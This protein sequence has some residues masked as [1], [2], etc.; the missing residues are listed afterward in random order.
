MGFGRSYTKP[1]ARWPTLDATVSLSLK[2][3]IS[4]VGKQQPPRAE[5]VED[6][7]DIIFG[8]RKT[9]LATANLAEA[10]D[11]IIADVACRMDND[12]AIERQIIFRV[13]TL[14]ST[15]LSVLSDIRLA[16]EKASL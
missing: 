14:Q 13:Q 7:R 16:S 1:F 2:R 4:F 5:P 8:H 15:G 10:L 3:S 6:L 9:S 11:H 12:R